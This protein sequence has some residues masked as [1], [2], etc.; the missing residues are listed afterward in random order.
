MSWET[1]LYIAV[2][3][4][5]ITLIL[6]IWKPTFMYEGFTVSPGDNK[7]MTLYFPRRGDIS[8]GTEE[9]GF[10]QDKRN[11]MGYADV[12]GLGVPHDFCRMVVPKG[13]DEKEKFFA[14]ALAGTENLSSTKYRTPKVA[15]GFKTSRDDYMRDADS[16]KKA[17]YCAIVKVKGG[18]W[19]PQCYRALETTFDTQTFID[20]KPP[21]DIADILYFYEGIMFW[22]RFIDDMKDYAEN[23]K[24]FAA[25]DLGI[26]EADVKVQPSQ[27]LTGEKSKIATVVKEGDVKVDPSQLMMGKKRTTTIEE[28]AQLTTGLKFNGSSHFLRLGDS[29]DMAFGQK[30]TLTTMRALCFWVMFDEFTNNAHIIDF[31]NGPGQDNVFVGIIGRGDESMEKGGTIR[32]GPCESTDLNMVLPDFPSGAQPVPEMTP[33][34]LMLSTS[35]NVENPPCEKKILPRYLPPLKPLQRD[36]PKDSPLTG[37]ATMVYEVW[38]GQLR[39]QHIKVQKAFRLKEWTHV[40]IT[41]ASGDGVRPALQIWINGKLIA[42]DPSAHLPQSSFTTNNYLGKSNWTNDSSQFE[43]RP[44]LFKGSLFDVRGYN[45]AVNEDKLK[46]TLRWGRQRLS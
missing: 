40:C 37:T 8:F 46:K 34:E 39:L 31:G 17:D 12:Q 32:K 15:D 7:F 3:L 33:Q 23:L 44:E 21:K 4:L 5:V 9:S 24:I 29:Q 30:I 26:N 45:Q 38:N 22:F 13:S 1:L 25:G 28:R 11:V 6:D 10:I 36:A 41:T 16:D 2:I 20:T 14:C 35:A 18:S 42:E 27:I 43:N 19:E